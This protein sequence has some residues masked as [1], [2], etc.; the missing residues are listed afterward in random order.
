[1]T[2]T[3]TTSIAPAVTCSPKADIEVLRLLLQLSPVGL[4]NTRNLSIES[5][6][7]SWRL[8]VKAFATR[9]AVDSVV[10]HEIDRGSFRLPLRIYRGRV[11][12]SPQPVLLWFHGG[13]FVF[14]DLYTA[15]ATCRALAR[16]TGAIVIAVD[17]RL[18]PEHSFEQARGDCLAA[19][20]WA[21]ENA[22]LFGG[23]ATRVAVGGDSAGGTF[24]ALAAL[25]SAA[26]GRPIA[27]MQVL[28]YPACDLAKD[29]RATTDV[30]GTLTLSQFTW[31][32][33]QIAKVSDL[34]DPDVSPL[35]HTIPPG[36]PA[37]VLI[38][39]GYDPLRD[40]A[41]EY[42]QKLA[43]AAVPVKVLH[44]PGQFHGFVSFDRVLAGAI[45]ALDRIGA[46]LEQGF[47]ARGIE[48]GTEVIS[49]SS[50][51]SMRKVMLGLHPRQRWHELQVACILLREAA[52]RRL[53]A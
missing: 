30:I 4:L 3:S 18:L 1:M 47:E 9:D 19:L 39:A 40:E 33:S 15:G 35:R 23:D 34:T 10:Q 43:D 6:R 53:M 5:V 11:S 46:V 38:T 41:L 52:Q 27:K 36:M 37:T 51:D 26:Q 42:G 31:L 49:I 29:Y 2:S 50:V 45:D 25:D 7:R 44:Y 48:A 20:Y 12:S 16:R 8:C 24:A 17:Y 32:R 14:G 21:A 22:A 28:V 13:G